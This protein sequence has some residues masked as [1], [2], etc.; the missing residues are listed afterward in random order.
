MNKNSL[1]LESQFAVK[2]LKLYLDQNPEKAIELAI[3]YF[4]DYLEL[5]EYCK[6]L[7]AQKNSVSLPL[8]LKPSLGGIKAEYDDLKE[9]YIKILRVNDSLRHKV[10]D[11]IELASALSNFE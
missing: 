2:R 1:S 3:S 10:K 4:E 11:L 7:E 9:E 8:F 6:K 5:I